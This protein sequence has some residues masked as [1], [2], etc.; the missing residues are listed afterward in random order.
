METQFAPGKEMNI[1]ERKALDEQEVWRQIE[2]AQQQYD[3]YR[4]INAVALSA[5]PQ[6]I[7]SDRIEVSSTAAPL[8]LCVY[9]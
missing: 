3:V 4:Q 1:E 8:T 2:L 7:T 6:F 5:G 9:S